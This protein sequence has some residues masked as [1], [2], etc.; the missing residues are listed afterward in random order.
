M[1]VVRTRGAVEFM[2]S[3]TAIEKAVEALDAGLH[4]WKLL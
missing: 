4:V 3:R 1:D 2:G